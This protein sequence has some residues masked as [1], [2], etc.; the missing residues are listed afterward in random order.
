MSNVLISQGF[1]KKSDKL[2]KALSFGHTTL[3]SQG[4][5][6]VVMDESLPEAS[7]MLVSHHKKRSRTMSYPSEHSA[8]AMPL[9]ELP[10]QPKLGQPDAST[11]QKDVTETSLVSLQY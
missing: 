4:K 7:T 5:V 10:S 11:S 9:L 6:P 2:D 1:S 8:H 3:D